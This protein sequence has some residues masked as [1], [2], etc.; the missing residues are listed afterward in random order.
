MTLR[1]SLPADALP[2]IVVGAGP[3]GLRCVE[4][5][6]GE[7][8]ALPIKLFSGEAFKP[9]DRVKLTQLLA[10]DI[11][12]QQ[13]YNS[14]P[15]ARNLQVYDNCPIV[16]IDRQ[17]K[18][19]QDCTGRLH[20]Y[21]K[22]VLAL[23][24]EPLRPNIPHV[25]SQNVFTFR[26]LKDTQA[27]AARNLGSRHSVV[28]GGGLLG[29]ETARAMQRNSTKV[30]IVQMPSHLMNQQLDY[31]AGKL[32]EAKVT[33]A[34][35]NVVCGARAAEIV[36]DKR[37][38]STGTGKVT[39]V[40]LDTGEVLECDTVIISAGIKPRIGLA[41]ES[42]LTVAKGIRVDQHLLTSDENI[43]AIG[44]CAQFGEQLFGLVAPGWEHAAVVAHHI[45]GAATR[46]KGTINASS[47]K[48]LGEQ[49]FSVGEVNAEVSAS[50]KTTVYS[51]LEAGIYRAIFTVNGTLTGALA[52]GEWPEQNR[53]RASIAEKRK[54]YAWHQ[55][56]FRKT[57]FLWGANQV[58]DVGSW[59]ASMVVCNCTGVTRGQLSAARS[60]GALTV[61][62]MA[63]CTRASTVCGSCKPLL[64]QF[65]GGTQQPQAAPASR[66]LHYC[67]VLGMLALA[68]LL[69]RG[70]W[71]FAASAALP[72]IDQ[73]WTNGFIKQVTGFT[74]LGL[75]ALSL[76]MSLSKRWRRFKL[77]RFT[78]WR[79]FH[80]TLGAA[81]LLVLFLHTG[82]HYGINLNRWLMVDFMLLAALGLAAGFMISQEHK[83]A[84]RTGKQ[85]RSYLTWGHTFL[86]WPLP[87]LLAFHIV[88]VYYF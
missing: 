16:A 43:Y 84:P 47:L 31:G 19:V 34:G 82:M 26:D 2:V 3:V 45:A 28:I 73:L 25:D 37:S 32:L 14:V 55:L 57:G 17:Q 76:L 22:L 9:Y 11:K 72:G 49:V 56:G 38:G 18:L 64:A 12:E 40:K 70:P 53:V 52:I 5:L 42:G 8:P 24:S 50:I 21:S 1:E 83:L 20:M 39:G 81:G 86:F 80:A 48:V 63:A 29:I 65:A 60:S 27:L 36:V 79:L 67:C 71:P 35:I 88:S 4:E 10:H 58:E 7:L 75:A 13:V 23:G 33:A 66:W 74:M 69:A 78:S 85:L 41:I 51:R 59:P 46:Y 62:A 68:V 6:L 15:V 87:A 54:I 30:T 61:E 77:G 44:E